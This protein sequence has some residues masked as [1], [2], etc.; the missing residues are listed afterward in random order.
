MLTTT[1]DY[2]SI[3]VVGSEARPPSFYTL[4]YHKEHPAR[5]QDTSPSFLFHIDYVN[6][7]KQVYVIGGSV[8]TSN[9]SLPGRR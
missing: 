9:L 5:E 4:K 6:M 3:P 2:T 7:P 1:T 8:S